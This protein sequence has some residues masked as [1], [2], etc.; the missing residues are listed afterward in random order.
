MEHQQAD[1][2]ALLAESRP[3]PRAR[4]RRARRALPG[5]RPR[6]CGRPRRCRG[7][8]ASRCSRTARRV[9][10]WKPH[11]ASP[12][13]PAAWSCATT[14]RRRHR[15]RSGPGRGPFRRRYAARCYG[16]AVAAV[17][18]RGA[19]CRF[20]HGHHIQ[21]LG[22]RRPDH[23]LQPRDCSAAD[24]TARSTR[25]AISS[26]DCPTG[27]SSS[28]G[29]TAGCCPRC[30]RRRRCL[31]TRLGPYGRSTTRKGCGCMPG[32]RARSGWG[33]ART[34]A[35]RSACC[36]RGSGPPLTTYTPREIRTMAI[37]SIAVGHSARM[38]MAINAV[39]AGHRAANAAP[40]EAPRMLTA[41]P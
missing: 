18:C 5:R 2:L 24:T 37:Q 9:S 4:S 20:G 26:S 6:R 38:G 11:S 17:A 36:I 39:I 33:S 12:A 41:C 3:P 35:G 19:G 25:R 29:R 14:A 10:S 40:L 13:T 22:A 23:A 1:A 7:S 30:R 16:V 15:S 31:R 8:P 27:R 34:W 32:R 28:D 21:A